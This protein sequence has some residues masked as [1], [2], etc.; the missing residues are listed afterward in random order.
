MHLETKKRGRVKQGKERRGNQKEKER[1]EGGRRTIRSSYLRSD[2]YISKTDIIARAY[3]RPFLIR[4]KYCTVLIIDIYTVI[5][6][7]YQLFILCTEQ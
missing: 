5:I 2:P 3:K 7:I 1:S 6:A 4:H